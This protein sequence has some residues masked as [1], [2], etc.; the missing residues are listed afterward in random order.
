MLYEQRCEWARL[1]M[2]RVNRMQNVQGCRVSL[3]VEVLGVWGLGFALIWD[4]WA[5]FWTTGCLDATEPFTPSR[6]KGTTDQGLVPRGPLKLMSFVPTKACDSFY[7]DLHIFQCSDFFTFNHVL[8]VTCSCILPVEVH[9]LERD[10]KMSDHWRGE[11]ASR[12]HASQKGAAEKFKSWE[13]LGDAWQPVS[14]RSEKRLPGPHITS[15]S[16][17]DGRTSC[18]EPFCFRSLLPCCGNYH[19]FDSFLSPKRAA[20]STCNSAL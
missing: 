17:E 18:S 3:G 10:Q 19:P 1:L 15:C 7:R 12:H 13:D 20:P 11:T 2:L 5:R 16:K 9:W 8:S 6:E 14:G 4:L